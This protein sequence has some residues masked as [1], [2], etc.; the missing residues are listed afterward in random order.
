VRRRRALFL[1]L[2]AG[3]TIWSV[4]IGLVL[5]NGYYQQ[6]GDDSLVDIVQNYTGPHDQ[7][8]PYDSLGNFAHE[9]RVRVE[10]RWELLWRTAT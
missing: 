7:P 6:S 5:W 9:L 10:D 1:A 4:W 3:C 8:P 2:F